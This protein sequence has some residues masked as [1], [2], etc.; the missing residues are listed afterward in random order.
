M[1]I[2]TPAIKQ[3]YRVLGQAAEAANLT[4]QGLAW[5][6]KMTDTF[7]DVQTMVCGVPDGSGVKTICREFNDFFSINKTSLGLT[8]PGV[9]ECNIA[10]LALGRS[11]QIQTAY[12]GYQQFPGPPVFLVN[13]YILPTPDQIN[14]GPVIGAVTCA[15]RVSNS[16][17]TPDLQLYPN[18]D[19]AN[20]LQETIFNP[21][22]SRAWIDSTPAEGFLINQLGHTRS[23]RLISQAFEV[24]NV[25]PEINRGGEVYTYRM[26]SVLDRIRVQN[27]L[28]TNDG[29]TSGIKGAATQIFTL[30]TDTLGNVLNTPGVMSWPA[31]KGA[32]C[33]ASLDPETVSHWLHAEDKKFCVGANYL[34][35]YFAPLIG[36]T[37][38]G[39]DRTF[40][41]Q[42]ETIATTAPIDFQINWLDSVQCGGAYFVN[43]PEET[44]LNIRV[45]QMIEY[46]PLYCD[47]DIVIAASPNNRDD[48]ALA[49]HRRM[50]HDFPT[51]CPKGMN[52]AGDWFRSIA[53]LIL[54]KA[55]V[56]GGLVSAALI[57]NPGPGALLGGAMNAAW[58]SASKGQKRAF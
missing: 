39:L 8:D 10:N 57:G 34:R 29:H 27:T 41:T 19:I 18:C 44:L 4:P 35:D 43:L 32:Y 37:P 16:T 5:L 58:G 30:P 50:V 7:Q 36:G 25:T 23:W 11:S 9:W 14:T 28:V 12:H 46:V 56:V 53:D 42:D 21:D 47:P 22:S 20:D 33:V 2:V 6:A 17:F 40:S 54:G 24:E 48:E 51:G 26:N 45:R 49:I 3:G 1:S 31:Y 52:A 55:V 38:A 13:G 15:A